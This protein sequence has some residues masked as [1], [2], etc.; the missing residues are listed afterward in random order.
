MKQPVAAGQPLE[1]DDGA[2][3]QAAIVT[4]VDMGVARALW[5][6]LAP[7]RLRDLLDAKAE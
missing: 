5:H 6:H 7:A 3:D 4:P 2:L 1:L